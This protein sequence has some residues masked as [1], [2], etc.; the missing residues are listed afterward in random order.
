MKLKV[1]ILF[2]AIACGVA[3]ALVRISTPPRTS[4]LSTTNLFGIKQENQTEVFVAADVSQAVEQGMKETLAAA[5]K[6]WGSSG[7]LEFWVLGADRAAAIELTAEFCARRVARGDMAERD[8]LDD[9]ENKDHGFLMYQAVGAV[10]LSSGQ[11]HMDAANNGGAEWG[12]HTLASSLPLGFSGL[13]GIAGEGDQITILHEYWHSVQRSFLQTQDQS[14]SQELMG[15]TWFVEGSAVAMA[16]ITATKLWASGELPKWNNSPQPWPTLEER[17]TNKMKIVQQLRKK[18]P[19]LL[20]KSYGGE[21]T[22]LAYESGGWAIL[23]LMNKFGEDVLRKTFHPDVE[24]LG[25]EECFRKTFGQSSA[26]FTVEFEKFMDLPLS[27][28]IKILPKY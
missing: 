13:L 24:R 18:C 5:V 26:E 20:P 16:E 8:C 22:Q 25:W 9:S 1:L 28:Q 6:S 2:L 3:F 12:I 10:A 11:P 14:R 23:Y 4:K 17:M 7:H 21:C 15:P 27:Q 19:S